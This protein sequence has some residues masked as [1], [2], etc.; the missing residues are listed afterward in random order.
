MHRA[1]KRVMNTLDEKLEEVFDSEK[2][3]DDLQLRYLRNVISL[4][5]ICMGI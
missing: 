4:N 5:T 1:A 3:C 2:V